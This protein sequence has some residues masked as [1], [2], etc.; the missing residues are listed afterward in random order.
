MKS[1]HLTD[2]EIRDLGW[3][4]LTERLGVAGALRFA[5]QTQRGHGDYAKIR[6]RLLG[7]LTVDQVLGMMSRRRKRPK[8]RRPPR[9]R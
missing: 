3:E 6:H 4:A 5:M 8:R 2:A 1:E 7:S 9:R